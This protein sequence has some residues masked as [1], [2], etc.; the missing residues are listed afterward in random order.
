MDDL[1][2]QVSEQVG[3]PEDT[4][5]QAVEVMVGY[6]KDHMPE[7]LAEQVEKALAGEDIDLGGALGSL[8]G[9]FN[10]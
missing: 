3:I 4:A 9:L 1:I 6:L 7:P 2:K 10:R 8:G 5:R